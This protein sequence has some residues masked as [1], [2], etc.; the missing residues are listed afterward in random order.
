MR[1]LSIRRPCW[2][3]KAFIQERSDISV[4]YAPPNF[5]MQL[6]SFGIHGSTIVLIRLKLDG[7]GF[8][9]AIE[10]GLAYKCVASVVGYSLDLTSR[11]TCASTQE[12]SPSTVLSAQPGFHSVT[13]L[14]LTYDVITLLFRPLSKREGH[15]KMEVV[16]PRRK[17][18]LATPADLDLDLDTHCAIDLRVV[19]LR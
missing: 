9:S 14:Y 16:V 5:V 7:E 15:Q 8:D 11:S 2:S 4:R 3:M 18:T 12:R 13:H 17:L 1:H 6:L 19:K 10:G